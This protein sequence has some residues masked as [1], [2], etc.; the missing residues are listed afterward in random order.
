M[1]KVNLMFLGECV[2]IVALLLLIGS[3]LKENPTVALGKEK[4]D[5]GLSN[6]AQQESGKQAENVQYAKDILE[7]RMGQDISGNDETVSGNSVSENQTLQTDEE[8]KIVVFG[9]SI[10]DMQRGT[11]G[12]SERLEEKLGVE[13]YNC[14]IGGTTAAVVSE[15]TDLREGWKSYS[16]NG[17]MYAARGEVSANS[18]LQNLPAL[19]EIK[20]IDFNEVDYL[21]ISYGLN[22]YFSS[23]EI[24][25]QD[26]YDMETYVGALRHA[27]A[28]MTETYPDLEVI[29]VSPTYCELYADPNKESLEAYAEGARMVAE[30]R[31]TYFWD[32]YHDLGIN[33]ENKKLYLSDG[34]HLSEQGR[35]LYAGYAAQ[36]LAEIKAE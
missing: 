34:V 9:D 35:E 15:S 21:I 29:L 27:V 5:Y 4:E 22:D 31:G 6:E 8:I 30:E 26:M 32:V 2:I 1:K 36:R 7:Q 16:L 25:P 12:I 17:M 20:S 18:L 28:K 11:D 13:I 3:L 23:V 33:E 14:A 24:Y 10:W 19:E